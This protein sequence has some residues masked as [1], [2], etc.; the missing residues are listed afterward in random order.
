MKIL[1][2]QSKQ[3]KEYISISIKIICACCTLTNEYILEI[4]YL[5]QYTTPIE[6][7]NLHHM[8]LKSGG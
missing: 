5:T 3:K 6:N 4:G 7:V 1:K 2:F 8:K